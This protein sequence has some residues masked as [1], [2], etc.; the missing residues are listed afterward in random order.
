MCTAIFREA[1]LSIGVTL[2]HTDSAR[3]VTAVSQANQA[4]TCVVTE[5]QLQGIDIELLMAAAFAGY[6]A[7]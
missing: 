3:A 6:L 4:F 2:L 7:R 5:S 1:R